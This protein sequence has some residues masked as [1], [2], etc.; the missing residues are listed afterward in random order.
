[1]TENR[2]KPAVSAHE[3]RIVHGGLPHFKMCRLWLN[4]HRFDSGHRRGETSN[5]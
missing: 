2:Q 1:M 4:K 5:E 3:I